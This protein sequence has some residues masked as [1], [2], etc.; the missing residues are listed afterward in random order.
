MDLSSPEPNVSEET[1]G[2]IVS[3]LLFGYSNDVIKLGGSKM[4]QI[5]DLPI[6]PAYM[7]ALPLFGKMRD[8][9]RT[10][11]KKKKEKALG[12]KRTKKK[13]KGGWMLL[14]MILKANR[15]SFLTRLSFF[16]M[17]LRGRRWSNSDEIFPS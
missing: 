1:S 8:V 13:G 7:R 10:A 17:A 9:Y 15:A 3:Q 14:G 12:E 4:L 16:L 2:P 6:S 5:K 11:M